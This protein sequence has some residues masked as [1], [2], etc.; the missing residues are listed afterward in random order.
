MG[1]APLLAE[2]IRLVSNAGR[3]NNQALA[4]AITEVYRRAG[5]DMTVQAIPAKRAAHML[6]TGEFDG[7]V[8]RVSSFGENRPDLIRLEPPIN[9]IITSAFYQPDQG[10]QIRS[11]EDLKGKTVGV[12]RGIAH[13]RRAGSMAEKVVEVERPEQL[14]LMLSSGRIDVAIH[15]AFGFDAALNK[16]ALPDLVLQE[17]QL[18]TIN[19]HHFLRDTFAQEAELIGSVLSEMVRTGTFKDLFETERARLEA[20]DQVPKAAD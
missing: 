10:Y 8:G 19:S 11:R 13:S 18:G 5:V 7:V 16:T 14:F 3:I 17:V 12:V 15:G 2:P 9:V 4:V 1:A 20:A 6:D